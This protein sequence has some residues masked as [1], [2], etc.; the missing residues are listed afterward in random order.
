MAHHGGNP[1]ADLDRAGVVPE[2]GVQ[3]AEVGRRH[4]QRDHPDMADRT[5]VA[6]LPGA[7]E[8]D[9]RATPSFDGPGRYARRDAPRATGDGIVPATVQADRAGGP[10]ASRRRRDEQAALRVIV[11]RRA[12]AQPDGHTAVVI[13]PE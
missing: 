10:A 7:I 2:A 13:R 6:V 8:R 3:V 9:G 4:P 12:P 5:D 11:T 1:R